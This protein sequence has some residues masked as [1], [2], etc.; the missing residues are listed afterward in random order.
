MNDEELA[1][2]RTRLMATTAGPWRSLVEGRDFLGGSSLI[3]TAGDDI[4]LSGAT[5]ADQ[6]FIAHAHEDI[7]SLLDEVERL[8]RD[9]SVKTER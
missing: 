5:V 1:S 2:I 3:T 8:R 4:Y 9:G 7:A 6:D